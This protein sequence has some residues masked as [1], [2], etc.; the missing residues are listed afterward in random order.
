MEVKKMTKIYEDVL[1]W[2]ILVIE[3]MSQKNEPDELL[4][5]LNPNYNEEVNNLKD[6]KNMIISRSSSNEFLYNIFRDY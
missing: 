6:A 1:E 2:E 5:Y 4:V 3:E